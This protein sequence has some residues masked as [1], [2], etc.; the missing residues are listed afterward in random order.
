MAWYLSACVDEVGQE[1]R[2]LQSP[3][4]RQFLQGS[5]GLPEAILSLIRCV[6][7]SPGS[8]PAYKLYI[9]SNCGQMSNMSGLLKKMFIGCVQNSPAAV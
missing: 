6:R 3:R 2:G 1:A 7:R 8:I 4:E 9:E 5:C